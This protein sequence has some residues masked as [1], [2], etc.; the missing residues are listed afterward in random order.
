[1]EKRYM[2]HIKFNLI[3]LG[4]LVLLS[5]LVTGNYTLSSITYPAILIY[6]LILIYK[7]LRFFK[8]TLMKVVL[9][10]AGFVGLGVFAVFLLGLAACRYTDRQD[11]Y[12]SR[13]NTKVKLVGRNYGCIETLDDLV[14]YKDYMLSD[15]IGIE[16]HYK[17]FTDYKNIDIDSTIWKRI[18]K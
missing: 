8:S 3:L 5:F 4:I 12:V 16:I 1:M 14:L 10:F 6:I 7:A 13:K 18:E 15:N 9:G 11:E 2:R 17:T